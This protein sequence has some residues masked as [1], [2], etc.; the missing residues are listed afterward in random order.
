MLYLAVA[1]LLF[2]IF[3]AVDHL[4]SVLEIKHGFEEFCVFAGFLLEVSKLLI[5]TRQSSYV[6]AKGLPP[7]A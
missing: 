2:S 5:L 4:Y 3:H 6:N 1:D 7:A